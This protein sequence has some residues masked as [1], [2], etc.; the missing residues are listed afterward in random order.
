MPE[1][2]P[3]T[4]KVAPTS[5]SF[6][7][8][9]LMF[10]VLTAACLLP[11]I[12]RAFHID[13]PLFLRMA[14]QILH[15]PWHPYD[16]EYNWDLRP[17]P[18]WEIVLNPPANS[19]LQAGIIRTLGKDERT[20][21]LVYL[22]LAC[23]CAALVYSISSRF[24]EHPSTATL[25]TITSPVLLVSATSVMADIPLLL[26]W[27]LCTRLAVHYADTSR[28]W[29]LWGACLAACA[30]AMTKY[31][32][33]ALVPLIAVYCLPRRHRSSGHLLA[34]GVPILVLVAW[35][36]YTDA[37]GDLFHPLDA[38]RF[39]V[40]QRGAMDVV[41][42]AAQS[43]TYFGAC[44]FW[45]ILLLPWTLRIGWRWLVAVLLLAICA[46][47]I[48]GYRIV[49]E[50]DSRG[51]E[52]FCI[53]EVGLATLAGAA[54]LAVAAIAW[55]ERPDSESALLGLWLFGTM[56]F[57]AFLNWTVNARVMLLCVFPAAL[58]AV[59]WLESRP[60]STKS[61]RW[62]RGAAMATCC[63]AL[64]VALADQQ[65]ADANREFA[66]VTA[67]RH[68]DRGE[69][70]WFAGHWGLQYY[71]EEVG[72][73]P[74][75]F[76]NQIVHNGDLIVYPAF[77]SQVRILELPYAHEPTVI[78]KNKYW[79]HTISPFARAGF[80]VSEV[81]SLPF[82]VGES[83]SAEFATVRV[84]EAAERNKRERP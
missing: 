40:G 46:T 78:I 24:C 13:D 26:C 18:A 42:N 30:A 4:E 15:D 6:A 43:V 17:R 82:N 27:L 49:A 56:F 73:R 64:A 44:L 20:L 80:Y 19:Y 3:K 79:F 57:I 58:L 70:M 72:A 31:F 54:L 25:L 10:A 55:R 48:D 21:H 83:R 69:R 60:D 34:L 68:L 67:K 35:G 81:A 39:A 84:V 28:P 41:R 74:I 47:A 76:R 29:A 2:G 12:D 50:E 32:G 1:G 63:I 36:V 9:A 52:V 61:L 59:R 16:F 66:Q 75:N 23:G 38:G 71:L 45:P 51:W 53:A 11:F 14:E 37:Q 77:N 7:W 33:F 5:R 65:F 8:T 62:S 22:C